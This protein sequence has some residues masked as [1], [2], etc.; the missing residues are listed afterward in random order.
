MMWGAYFIPLWL[1]RQEE[2]SEA[3]SVDRFSHAMRIL[4]RRNP[5]LNEQGEQPVRTPEPVGE[6]VPLRAASSAASARTPSSGARSP[7]GMSKP[8]RR[9]FRRRRILLAL[10]LMTTSTAMLTPFTPITWPMALTAL[11]ATLWYVVHLRL[12][13]RGTRAMTRTRESVRRRAIARLR[14]LDTAERIFQARSMLRAERAEVDVARAL[15]A[16]AAC[17]T[18][19]GVTSGWDPVP[20]PLPTYV[21][22]PVA[23]RPPA[24][25][26]TDEGAEQPFDQVASAQREPSR[27]QEVNA[28]GQQRRAV[29]D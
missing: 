19:G 28:V 11:C 20:V 17:G 21:T 25:A 2:R 6:R 27:S 15:A 18:A 13:A 3:R 12:Q 8:S 9:T 1:R 4:S 29:N 23:Q 7:S 10:F 24:P 26:R 14:R 5:A 16:E 22:K